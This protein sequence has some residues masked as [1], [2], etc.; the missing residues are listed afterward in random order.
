MAQ[1][2]RPRLPGL[3]NAGLVGIV[4]SVVAAVALTAR[5]NPPPTVAEFAPQAVEQIE[6]ALPEQADAPGEST[7]TAGGDPDDAAGEDDAA[8][9]DGEPE[10]EETPEAEPTAPETDEPLPERARVRRC[11][12]NPPRQT[13][14]PQSPPCV[15]FFDGDNGGA[16]AQGVTQDE[17]RI[18]YPNLQFFGPEP[19]ELVQAMVDHFNARYEFYG[20]KIVLVEYSTA[21]FGSPDPPAMTADAILV[22]EQLQAFGSLGYGARDGAEHHYYDELA[23]R[24][25]VSTF[26]NTLSLGTEERFQRFDPHQWSWSATVDD[27]FALAGDFVCSTLAG[28]PPVGGTFQSGGGALD[29]SESVRPET[30]TFGLVTSRSADGTIP[31]VESLVDRMEACGHAPLVVVEDDVANPQADNIILQMQNAGVTTVLCACSLAPFRGAYMPAASRQGYFPEWVAPGFGAS[32]LDNSF[33]PTA[34][35]PEQARNVLGI[36]L[37]N[38]WLER[39]QMPWY[40]AIRETRPDQDPSGGIYYTLNGRYEHLLL[41]ASGIQLAG[42]ELTPETFARGLQQAKFP[43]PGA[44]GS[45]FYQAAVDFGSRHAARASASLFWYSPDAPGTFQPDQLGAV[46]YLDGGT[47]YGFGQFPTEQQA[48]FQEPCI[49]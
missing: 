42:P 16:T 24:G 4:V 21:A 26:S 47:R 6:E 15:P 30:R 20:R 7:A 36:A 22:D 23:R 46:C 17:I 13:E 41:M 25:I 12:G 40:W 10:A 29:P 45:P 27:G 9:P 2:A 28:K 33:S 18:A 11:V 39:Q 31:P 3:V 1:G 48:W 14:D 8:G 32:D 34:A 43:N 44:G 49:R 19:I 38:R 37:R 5:Q 35:P